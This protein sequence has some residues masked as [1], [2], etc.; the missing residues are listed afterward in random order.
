MTEVIGREAKTIH[1][2]LEWKAGAFQVNDE[3]P[4]QADY[5]IVDE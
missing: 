1:R 3:S 5:L 4:L 2:L